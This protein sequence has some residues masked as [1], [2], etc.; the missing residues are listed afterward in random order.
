MKLT[1][2][3][4][5]THLA[6]ATGAAASYHLDTSAPP[7]T[8]LSTLPNNTLFH[9]WRPRA[10]ILPVEGQIGDPCAHYTDPATGL[11]HVGFLHDGEGIAGATTANL[12][13]YTDTSGNGSFLIQPG[14]KND[15]VAVFDGAV[16]PVGV[17][18]TPT[19]LYTSVS[20]LPI[21]WSIP[22]TRG[23][24]TQSL[25]VA[26]DGGRR[27]EKLDQG[28]VIADHPFA[29]DVTAFRDPFVFRSARLDTL[30]SLDE[31]VARNETAV[32]DAVDA[33]TEKNAPW[34][35]AVSGGVHGIGPA[36]FLYR[37]NGGNGSE[38]QYWE[39]LGEW[40]QEATNSSWGEEGTWAGRW[41]FNFETGNVLF[42][43]EEGHDPKTGEVFV[44]LGTEGSDL[45]IVPQ[46]S[47][48]H[49]MLWAAGEVGVGSEDGAKVEFTPSM[50]GYLDWGFSAYAAAGKVLP[51]SS[52][53]SKN[54]GAEVDRYISFV[55]LT[56]DQYEQADGFPTAQQGWTGSLLL[57]REL[58]VQAVKN[59][60]DNALVREEGVSWVVGES[61]NKTAT[62]R[63]L[64]ITIAR[65]TKAALL[66][67]GSVTAEE[68]RTLQTAAVVP[69]IQF[70]GSKFFVLTAQL[71]FPASARAS[72]LQ[73]G[74]E[75]LASEL[76]RTTV[77]YQFSNESLVV[78]RS[79][80]S[81]AAPTNP[82][83][84]RF[85]ESGKLRLFDVVENGQEK[86]E[87]LDLTVVVDNSVVE[88]YANGR[89]ALSTW[90]RSWYDNST[91]IRFFHN[92]EG[93]VQFKNVSVSEGLYNA[94][95][96]RK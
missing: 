66:A 18:N 7:P 14:G 84:D 62:L 16:I 33:W 38:F 1:T 39:Y 13:T 72:D 5:T 4:T 52:A 8:N 88:V 3:T 91:Q 47:S 93:E 48:I 2:T 35:V 42:L 77:Y 73:S 68:D 64:G 70:P 63:T 59:V 12:A 83:L 37:Q 44:T 60:V 25:A 55:W 51:A 74:F 69:F 82:G 20:F 6:L 19:L 86:V 49:D 40:W 43:T 50:A 96:E 95:P 24:E 65:E 75:I 29:V 26:R 45:P 21:H 30:L 32:Q 53:V 11:F 87:T 92:G 41:G 61:N 46:V 56:G 36:Q 28:P 54:S 9:L 76:E 89:F 67:N 34:Y 90:A 22:Y 71:E 57:P 80:T 58:K 10:H 31:E 17:N 23:S 78:D 15:P 94:W 79:Q 27:F 81:A 85:A